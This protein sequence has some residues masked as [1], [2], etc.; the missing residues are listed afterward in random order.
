MV[1]LFD[2]FFKGLLIA[3]LYLETTKVNDTTF[4]NIILFVAF[5]LSMV[6]GA[7]LAK[8]D[9]TVIT[10]A[11]LT[12]TVFTLIDERIKRYDNKKVKVLN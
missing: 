7:I 11:F 1:N 4:E 12:K 6:L 5:Y 3:I 9:T 10:G 8:V 2:E